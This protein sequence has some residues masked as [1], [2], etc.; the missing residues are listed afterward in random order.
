MGGGPDCVQEMRSWGRLQQEPAGSGVQRGV[1]VLVAVE[2]GQHDHADGEP[3]VREDAPG[4]GDA[5]DAG[6]S[7]VEEDHIGPVQQGLADCLLPVARLGDHLDVLLGLED[8][9]QAE[10]YQLLVVGE[11]DA[12]HVRSL[13]RTRNPP[14]GSGPAVIE[15][16]T[17]STR[18]TMPRISHPPTPTHLDMG[19]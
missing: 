13:A 19:A 8:H 9:P 4:G 3:G 11:Q 1:E 17:R 7:D 10:P 5:V 14:S 6:H 16:P 12:D 18:S 2:R 15:P